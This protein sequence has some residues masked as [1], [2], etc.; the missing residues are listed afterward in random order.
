MKSFNIFILTAVFCLI[1]MKGIVAQ[2]TQTQ[3]NQVELMK[4]FTG[5]WKSEL[6]ERTTYISE[7]KPFGT[8]MACNVQILSNGV[9]IDSVKQLYGYD[10][11]TDKYII[12]ELIQSSSVLQ[13]S[14]AW[15]TSEHT[16]KLFMA[17][18]DGDTIKFDF[19]FKTPD[20][21]TQ[22]AQLDNKITL[23]LTYYRVK[24]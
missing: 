10:K 14:S 24:K 19:E 5:T 1:N 11:R 8:G 22:I 13:L 18:P 9:F 7:N 4:Q 15:F 12:A 23:E 16:G 17:N 3:L 20:V 21:I 2:N 6:A